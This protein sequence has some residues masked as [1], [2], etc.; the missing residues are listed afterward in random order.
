MTVAALAL[1]A[2]ERTGILTLLERALG[3]G[4]IV[5][6]HDVTPTPF[7]PGMHVTVRTFEAQLEFLAGR[8][9]IVPLDEFVRR[10]RGGRSLRGCVA[11]TFDDAYRGARE[12]ALPLLERMAIPA[13]IFVAT[14]YSARPRRFWWDRLEWLTLT[15]VPEHVRAGLTRS[16]TG[17]ERADSH[18]A[19][20]A[21][22]RRS[23]GRLAPEAERAL[24]HAEETGGQVPER[25]LSETELIELARSDLIDF[26]SHTVSHPALPY[27]PETEQEWEIR[28]S[29]S[30]LSERLPRVRAF[31][32]YPFGLYSRETVRA[33]R[34][35]GMEAGF[36]LAGRA[37][38]F[39][40]GLHTC[41]RIGVAE[42]NA[43]LSL[44]AHLGW[45][46]VPLIAWRNR[47]WHPRFP[48]S[49]ARLTT[50][51]QEDRA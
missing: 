34:R 42:T 21:L 10:R 40:F 45:W 6:Y 2:L 33:A 4:G 50:H 26:G 19:L 30:W 32:A 15:A 22:L 1:T 41:P 27:L 49:D 36:S 9:N 16:V 31:L 35:A 39:W 12:W 14:D 8:Y 48:A 28:T 23:A 5:A 17:A 44:R 47:E 51:A 46:A 3:S 11:I 24:Q 38:A 7:L 43:A 20:T 37:A 25:P 13:T 29:H 18:Q